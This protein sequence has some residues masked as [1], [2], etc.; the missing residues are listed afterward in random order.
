M[1]RRLA[2]ITFGSGEYQAE[3]S[4]SAP[5]VLAGSIVL[6]WLYPKATDDHPADDALVAR[7]RIVAGEPTAGV[8]FTVY[9]FDD[10]DPVPGITH[11]TLTGQWFVAFDF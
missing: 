6:A 7:I 3:A 5:D 11:P 9:A 1:T 10:T 4:I 2:K 8:G